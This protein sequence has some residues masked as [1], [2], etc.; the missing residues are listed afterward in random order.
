M[1]GH[2]LRLTTPGSHANRPPYLQ[3]VPGPRLPKIE[4]VPD[5]VQAAFEFP[6]MI[7][8][9][10]PKRRQAW[11]NKARS[12]TRRAR[13]V[14]TA[15]G[16]AAL[17]VLSGA[18]RHKA[19][20]RRRR[21]LLGMAGAALAVAATVTGTYLTVRHGLG[22]NSAGKLQDVH[23]HALP[24]GIM[25][26]TSAPNPPVQ[27]PMLSDLLPHTTSLP[28]AEV[29]TVSLPTHTPSGYPIN[30][31]TPWGWGAERFG[32]DQSLTKLH[33]LGDIALREGHQVDWLTGAQLPDGAGNAQIL[34]I[35]GSTSQHVIDVLEQAAA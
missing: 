26:P 21:N 27:T 28:H 20:H 3:V 32:S 19:Q 15:L 2:K 23:E 1:A 34:M 11:A 30:Y 4:E 10:V 5:D 33:A 7:P 25:L 24:R 16:A 9:E 31:N 35:D 13:E 14:P 8:A 17:T 6:L 22:A 12:L 18:E 29:A